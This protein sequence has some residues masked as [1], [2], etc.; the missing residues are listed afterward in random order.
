MK[1]NAQVVGAEALASTLRKAADDLGDMS[2]PA[3]KTASFLANRGRIDA[4][5]RTG[6]L[7]ASVHADSDR[8]EARVISGL[9]YSN[10]THWGY[11]RYGQ[12][13]QPW[14]AE[15]AHRTEAL[16]SGN[17]EDRVEHCLDEVKGA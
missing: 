16:W 10:R 2:D 9:V 12:A 5:R 1:V 13:A 7:A 14:L 3:Q 8:T 17:Y 15:G 6:R 4:P 11:A